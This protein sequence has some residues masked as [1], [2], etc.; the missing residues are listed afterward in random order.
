M[1]KRG[2]DEWW[3][4]QFVCVRLTF[5]ISLELIYQVYAKFFYQ[6]KKT[7]TSSRSTPICCSLLNWPIS[8]ECC[9]LCAW[10]KKRS[11]VAHCSPLRSSSVS[12]FLS[13]SHP[14]EKKTLS[15]LTT[16]FFV[17]LIISAIFW[18]GAEKQLIWE[19]WHVARAHN[20]PAPNPTDRLKKGLISAKSR[21]F[22]S[23]FTRENKKKTKIM[24]PKKDKKAAK[25][26]D[27]KEEGKC[28]I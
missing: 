26:D 20:Q 12:L 5:S 17:L 10:Q 25:K 4:C 27:S 9:R 28:Y 13:L 1:L 6:K 15:L 19:F 14:D 2:N 23:F 7:V 22:L 11:I 24:P 3:L 18:Y 16:K 21:I 8:V